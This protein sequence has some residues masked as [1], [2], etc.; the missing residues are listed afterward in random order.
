MGTAPLIAA[1]IDL[2]GK[3]RLLDLGGGPGTFAIHFCRSNPQL[4][5]VVFDRLTTEPF[6][7]KTVASF[8]LSGRIDFRAGDFNRDPF[9]DHSFDAAWLSHV[10][11]SNGPAECEN[12]ISKVYNV[13]EPGGSILIHDFILADTKDR[14]EFATLFSLN[15]LINNSRGR[16]YSATEITA[17]LEKAGFTGCTM[18]DPKTVNESSILTAVKA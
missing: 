18:I 4:N 5:A 13:L 11:H 9:G 1:A 3:H 7:R 16:A 8:N 15:M 12:I 6:M 10:L 14:P 17:M 2:S